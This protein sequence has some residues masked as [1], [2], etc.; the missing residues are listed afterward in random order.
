MAEQELTRQR[1]VTL[2]TRSLSSP[3][4]APAAPHSSSASPTDPSARK[5]QAGSE[6]GKDEARAWCGVG[7][8]RG[9]GAAAE[10]RVRH[11]EEEFCCGRSSP[12]GSAAV[13]GICPWYRCRAC[14]GAMPQEPLSRVTPG[15]PAWPWGS[16]LVSAAG[17]GRGHLSN[18]SPPAAGCLPQLGSG[19]PP[20]LSPAAPWRGAAA[21]AGSSG[22]RVLLLGFAVSRNPPACGRVTKPTVPRPAASVPVVPQVGLKQPPAVALGGGQLPV[23]GSGTATGCGSERVKGYGQNSGRRSV[24]PGW[25]W[26]L[27]GQQNRCVTPLGAVS[28]AGLRGG[29]AG[30]GRAA[31][32]AARVAAEAGHWV[33]RRPWGCC[34]GGAGAD[35]GGAAV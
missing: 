22:R 14:T 23:R 21:L 17:D 15:A 12:C 25:S 19:L 34:S 24:S 30:P 28:P 2:G 27:K 32:A 13:A 35:P 3:R 11:V 31:G 10:P 33:Q 16:G 1:G 20:P 9:H 4:T 18:T 5:V 26:F 8:A 29:E 7:W 6:S